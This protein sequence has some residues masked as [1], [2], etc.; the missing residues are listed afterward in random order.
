MDQFRMELVD[1][2]HFGMSDMIIRGMSDD[3]RYEANLL[4]RCFHNA[5][6]PK[7][8]AGLVESLE[9]FIFVVL[10]DRHFHAQQF[11]VMCH[12][13]SLSLPRLLTM[14]A[15]KQCLN[16]FRWANGYNLPK[17]H[18][19]KYLKHWLSPDGKAVR[20]DNEHL[21]DILS[22]RV[23]A[24]TDDSRLLAGLTDG[25][26]DQAVYNDLQNRY[27]QYLSVCKLA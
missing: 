9:A 4:V 5:S 16:K 10:H 18:P 13:A 8:S 3:C 7:Y 1:I 15:G 24:Q 26:I 23:L 12:L 17:D 27:T 19:N 22:T 21:S 11:A 2:F 20:E 14:Y 25:S 6:D